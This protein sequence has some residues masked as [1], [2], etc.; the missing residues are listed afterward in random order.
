M[1]ISLKEVIEGI[2]DLVETSVPELKRALYTFDFSQDTQKNKDYPA[3]FIVSNQNFTIGENVNTTP[4]LLVFCDVTGGRLN[5]ID[6]DKEIK[7]DMLQAASK[8]LDLMQVNGYIDGD[9]SVDAQPFSYGLNN[10]L[11]GIDCIVPITIEKPCYE[12]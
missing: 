1:K 5:D 3:L 8:L 4:L 7:S 10:A 9:I 2:Q 11:S 12:V 6:R